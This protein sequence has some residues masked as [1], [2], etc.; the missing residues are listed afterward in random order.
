VATTAAVAFS[1]GALT[2]ANG[3]P[4]VLHK[5][6]EKTSVPVI[7]REFD[8]A[9]NVDLESQVGPAL[10]LRSSSSGKI[11]KLSCAAGTVFTSGKSN[12]SIAGDP[13]INLATETPLWRDL[14]MGDSG[15]DVVALQSQLAA[16]GYN[17]EGNGIVGPRMLQSVRDLM[18]ANGSQNSDGAHIAADSFFWIPAASV[19]A[20]A[21][22]VAVGQVIEANDVVL[23]VSGRL[24]SV[25]LKSPPTTLLPGPRV[26]EVGGVEVPVGKDGK[27]TKASDLAKIAETPE[28]LDSQS[29]SSDKEDDA[30]DSPFQASYK[31][32]KP[33]QV[34][35]V[36][37][38]AV[39]GTK[40]DHACVSLKNRVF[41][42][43]VVGSELGQS[44]V[45]F[46]KDSPKATNPNPRKSL[47][48]K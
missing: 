18:R 3:E 38:G 13:V 34:S 22:S 5:K 28:F 20:S 8:D 32:A 30:E 29:P 24:T 14:K 12:F 15:T 35:V 11:T 4:A 42:V 26:L 1:A 37:P 9:K 10:G 2:L 23:T 31:L 44:F 46:G 48:C 36:P 17:S 47:T 40:E 33:S 7:T 19:R 16:L 25:T 41:P 39:F 43:T 45:V 6:T 27:V 21:C